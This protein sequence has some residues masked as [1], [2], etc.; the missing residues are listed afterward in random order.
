MSEGGIEQNTQISI[1]DIPAI[2]ES[3]NSLIKSREEIKDYVEQP[4]VKACEHFWD[5]NVRTLSSSANAKDIGYGAYIILDFN[6][7][8]P[9]NQKVAREFGDFLENYDGQPAVKIEFPM[10]ESTTL[11]QIETQSKDVAERFQKQKATWIPSY[12]IQQMR[13]I[14]AIDPEDNQYGAADFTEAGWFYDEQGGKFYQSEEL[15]KK[16]SEQV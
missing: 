7:L 14:Y 8:A 6:S 2:Q 16:D 5:L 1:S 11:Q 9:D 10:H 4:L 13:R 15:F 3:R 12:S